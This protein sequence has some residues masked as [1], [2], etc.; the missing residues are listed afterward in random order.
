MFI[1]VVVLAF[2]ASTIVKKSTLP[3]QL[4][5][6]GQSHFPGHCL[7]DHEYWNYT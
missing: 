2:L 1:A 4:F 5:A 7:V 3:I 6:T